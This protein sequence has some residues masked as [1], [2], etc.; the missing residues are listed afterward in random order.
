MRTFQLASVLSPS[1]EIE[2]GGKVARCKPVRNANRNPNF[3]ENVLFFEIVS[4]F[5][6]CDF[7]RYWVS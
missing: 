4:I 6:G 7:Q 5:M 1:I 3:D 2:I